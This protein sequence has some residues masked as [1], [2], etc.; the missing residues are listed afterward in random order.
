[1]EPTGQFHLRKVTA[2]IWVIGVSGNAKQ[3]RK[4]F[5]LWKRLGYNPVRFYMSGR[6][7]DEAKIP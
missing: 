2:H 3:R 1:M 5:R 7:G 6:S 4:T